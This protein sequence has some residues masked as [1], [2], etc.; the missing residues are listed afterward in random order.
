MSINLSDRFYKYI[1]FT[2][3]NNIYTALVELIT[4]SVDAYNRANI[5]K[6]EVFI[7]ID[8]VSHKFYIYDRA[9]GIDRGS[10]AECFGQVGEYTSTEGSRGFF[11]KGSKDVSAIGDMKIVSIKDNDI[12]ICYLKTNNEF[13]HPSSD[14]REPTDEERDQ[15]G[16][17]NNGLF[18]EVSLSQSFKLESYENVLKLSDYYSLRDIFT[19]ENIFVYICSDTQHQTLLKSNINDKLQE[20]IFGETFTVPNYEH[21]TAKFTVFHKKPEFR[22]KEEYNSFMH[23]GIEIKDSTAIY[24]INTFYNDIRSHPKIY[25]IYAYL[26]TDGIS[27]LMYGFDNNEINDSNPF[28][29]LN[30]SRLGNINKDHPFIKNLYSRPHKILKFILEELYAK[31]IDDSDEFDISEI[32]QDIDLF[33]D[34]FYMALQNLVLPNKIKSTENLIKY[35]KKTQSNVVDND[36]DSKY[37][38]EDL[39][40]E[41]EEESGGFEKKIPTF[42]VKFSNDENEN[43]YRIFV[44]NQKVNVIINTN[45][46]VLSKYCQYVD[47]KL[48]IL[49]KNKFLALLVEIVSEG[50]S[51][52][53]MKYNRCFGSEEVGLEEIETEF[54]KYRRLFSKQFYKY[55]IEYD[56]LKFNS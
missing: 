38:S 27:S 16:I 15:Y 7:K 12:S 5:E 43:V 49:E 52:Q 54:L 53:M 3:I 6:K 50:F 9:T 25:D 44:D 28:P 24:D 11:S 17:P 19:D 1:K 36:D 29:V 42:V 33:D 20:K 51:F 40:A 55:F 4:N 13:I 41:F 8:Y 45:D 23:Y 47:N 30:P 14:S 2:S 35:I 32:F 31:D 56:I 39:T 48:K 18:I 34:D 21:I 22:E 37:N 10:L 26:E 46:F